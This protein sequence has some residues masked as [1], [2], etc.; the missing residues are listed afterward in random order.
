M[1]HLSYHDGE[2]YNSV[3]RADDYSRGTAADIPDSLTPIADVA[4]VGGGGGE[5]GGRCGGGGVGVPG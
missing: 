4:Q 1:L 3:R 5:G 2:H